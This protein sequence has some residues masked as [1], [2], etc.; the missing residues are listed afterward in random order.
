MDL[1]PNANVNNMVQEESSATINCQIGKLMS[2]PRGPIKEKDDIQKK[3]LG[4]SIDEKDIVQKKT[5]DDIKNSAKKIS[6][7]KGITY[8]PSMYLF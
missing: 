4:D 7:N 2:T 3:I 8:S 1:K 6:P 5:L